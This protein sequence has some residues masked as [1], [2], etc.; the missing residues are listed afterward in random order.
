VV[1]EK[2]M[3][4]QTRT[5]QVKMPFEILDHLLVVHYLRQKPTVKTWKVLEYDWEFWLVRVE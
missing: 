5:M 1:G 2:E 4:A 3:R